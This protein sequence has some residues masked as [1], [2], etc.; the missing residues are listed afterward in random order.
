MKLLLSVYISTLMLSVAH[1]DCLYN[2]SCL[3]KGYTWITT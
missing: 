3:G 2:S 1:K